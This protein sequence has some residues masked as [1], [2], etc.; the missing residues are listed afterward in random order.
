MKTYQRLFIFTLLALAITALLSPW[1]AAAWAHL[2]AGRADWQH[3]QY[4]FSRI[5]SRFFMVSGIG[6]FIVFRR[7]LKLG[8]LNELGLKPL[9]DARRDISLGAV[10]SLASIGALIGVMSFVDIFT[11]FFRLSLS[12][13]LSRCAGAL[14]AAIA[15]SAIE[16]VFFRGIFFEGLSDDLGRVRGYLSAS[17]LFSAIH[18]VRPAH[19]SIL[20]D[21]DPWAGIRHLVSSFHPF[22]DPGVFLPGLFGL[23]I[24]GVILCYAFER[25]GTLYLSIGLHAGWIFG[26]K[27]IRVFGDYARTDLTWV[28]GSSD[29]KIVSGVA[30]WIGIVLVGLMIHQLTLNRTRLRRHHRPAADLMHP[31]W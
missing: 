26:L 22:L 1:A 3:Y 7:F 30:T 29:P 14:L 23:F 15:A 4:S 28:F 20:T 12:A 17:L 25:T 18:F 19:D 11:P 13:S 16:E 27:T 10:L 21:A 9:T 2:I 8:S 5:F 6:L 31:I 24:I